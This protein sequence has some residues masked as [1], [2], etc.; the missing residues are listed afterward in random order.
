MH[1]CGFGPQI[2]SNK[3]KFVNCSRNPRIEA[4]V[5]DLAYTF[6]YDRDANGLPPSI[7][8]SDVDAES[9]QYRIPAL[10]L[11][12]SLKT[13]CNTLPITKIIDAKTLFGGYISSSSFRRDYLQVFSSNKLVVLH[14]SRARH[15]AFEF[16]RDTE[17]RNK[18]KP[19]GTYGLE[20][21]NE[22]FGSPEELDFLDVWHADRFLKRL[23]DLEYYKILKLRGAS[24]SE[25][26]E[27][28]LSVEGYCDEREECA[29][30]STK[31]VITTFSGCSA[32][33]QYSRCLVVV[34]KK[35]G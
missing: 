11:N 1:A 27:E 21:I 5:T 15:S 23:N 16:L 29:P 10:F 25:F 19:E 17:L 6:N 30:C 9:A 22:V 34:F 8:V 4:D 35:T 31:T 28:K 18:L 32:P 12:T 33:G 14:D 2:F 20:S 3:F 13:P 26:V 24:L 7:Y